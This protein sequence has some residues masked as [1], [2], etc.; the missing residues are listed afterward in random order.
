MKILTGD[1]ER[2]GAPPSPVPR[3]FPA[4]SQEGGTEAN[5]TLP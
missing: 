3:L 2:F 5:I 4:K 1:R